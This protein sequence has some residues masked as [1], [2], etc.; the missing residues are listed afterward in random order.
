MYCVNILPPGVVDDELSMDVIA[1]AFADIARHGLIKEYVSYESVPFG[2]NYHS[3]ED[4]GHWIEVQASALKK[5]MKC[6]VERVERL[7]RAIAKSTGPGS[8]DS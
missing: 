7:K 3:I 5:G 2:A 1:E 6:E 8:I 4:K